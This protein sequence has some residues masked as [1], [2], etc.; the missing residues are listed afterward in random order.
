MD[1]N[2]TT[3]VTS[4]LFGSYDSCTRGQLVT[5]LWRAAGCPTSTSGITFDDVHAGAYCYTAVRWA[6][7]ENIVTGYGD[8]KFGMNDIVTREQVAAILFRFAQ[9]RGLVAVTLEENLSAF[10]DRDQIS[11]YAVSA[12]NWAVGQGIIN[13]SGEL[14]MPKSPCV[15]SQVVTL[16]ERLMKIL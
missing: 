7:S 12:M 4:T 14:L 9:Y 13:G 11:G 8:G 3:G 10:A 5:F 2:I 16:L 15:R 1:N 6:V